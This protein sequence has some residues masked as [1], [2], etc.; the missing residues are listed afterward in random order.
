MQRLT[1]SDIYFLVLQQGPM[2]IR[3]M[4]E[5]LEPDLSPEDRERHMQRVRV[6]VSKMGTEKKLF[7]VACINCHGALMWG[8]ESPKTPIY[9]HTGKMPRASVELC[10]SIVKTLSESKIGC[11]KGELLD[12]AFGE[13]VKIT[14]DK[15]YIFNRSMRKLEREGVIY[16][17]P[18]GTY[19]GKKCWRLKE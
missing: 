6:H 7:P 13:C 17:M 5:K 10:K 16:M 18:P 19:E 11:S 1:A 2:D 8:T 9:R 14:N 15:M 4:S 12:G 3:T